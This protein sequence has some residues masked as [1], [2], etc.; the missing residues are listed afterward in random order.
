VCIGAG[1]VLRRTVDVPSG[2]MI[3][4]VTGGGYAPGSGRFP[5]VEVRQGDRMVTALADNPARFY[6]LAGEYTVAVREGDRLVRPQPVT[7]R[8]GDEQAVSIT[9]AP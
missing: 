7:L 4:T 6:M 9:V 8:A 1:E 2:R 5:M 3:V